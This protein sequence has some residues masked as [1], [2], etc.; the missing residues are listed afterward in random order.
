MSAFPFLFVAVRDLPANFA[1]DEDSSP[2]EDL[3]TAQK[4]QCGP[5]FVRKEAE[6]ES[7]RDRFIHPADRDVRR[8]DTP[9]QFP[10]ISHKF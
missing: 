5:S 9:I 8:V 1:R 2:Y 3:A 10:P 7:F 6:Y 4:G